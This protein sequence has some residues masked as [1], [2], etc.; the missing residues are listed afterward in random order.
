M[1]QFN[2]LINFL[3]VIFVFT[4]L[5][6]YINLKSTLDTRYTALYAEVVSNNA[7]EAA[8]LAI[9]AD[10]NDLSMDYTDIA[11][12]KS[13]PEEAKYAFGTILALAENLPASE[14]TVLEEL[15]DHVKVMAICVSD[16]YY[17]YESVPVSKDAK[18]LTE[19]EISGTPKLPYTYK[20]GNSL[21]ALNLQSEE[22]LKV[23]LQD[24][25]TSKTETSSA[26][27]PQGNVKLYYINKLI[28]EEING[29]VQRLYT[30][31]W[32]NSVFI[33][34]SL[35]DMTA[36]NPIK[37]T[38]VLCLLDGYG[39]NQSFGIG[40]TKLE[41]RTYYVGYEKNGIKYYS[42][43]KASEIAGLENILVFDTA[44][45]AANAG[46]YYNIGY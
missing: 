16:G 4:L 38:T 14:S 9:A 22:T 6:S 27:L 35:G 28:S 26:E 12:F 34:D 18:G 17:M 39:G 42:A 23:S 41:N 11:E 5:V 10:T 46:Y 40:G 19:Y 13:D 33:P 37:G 29:R 25:T 44:A 45:D 43:V 21:Y 31:G 15:Q 2:W 7:S 36:T 30:H 32:K 3:P 24:L 20:V 1:K 8:V